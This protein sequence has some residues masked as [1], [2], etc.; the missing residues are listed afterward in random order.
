[1]KTSLRS[2]TA[3][4]ALCGTG[5]LPVLIPQVASATVVIQPS[6]EDMTAKSQVII[7]A[8]VEDQTVTQGQDGKRILTLSRLRVTEAVK[9]GAKVNDTSRSTRWAVS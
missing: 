3:A 6:L 5:A 7:H 9:G 2:W 4:L 1:M 8:V